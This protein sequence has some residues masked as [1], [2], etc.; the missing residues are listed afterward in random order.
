MDSPLYNGKSIEKAPAKDNNIDH[1]A[2]DE[3]GQLD[4]LCP[5]WEYIDSG[6]QEE[7]VD[8]QMPSL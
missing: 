6:K 5:P 2:G 1:I 4:L 8:R 7:A 3:A